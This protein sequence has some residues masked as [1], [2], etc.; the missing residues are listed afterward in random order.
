MQPPETQ[1]VARP[2]GVSIAY[3]VFG[4]GPIDLLLSPGLAS[5][6]DMAWA[7][8]DLTRLFRR[9]VGFARV[10]VY[11]KPGTGL[12]DP[13]M[14]VPTLEERRDD[15]RV[16]L[17]AV[18]SE[19]T[20]LLGFSEGGPACLLFAATH[21]ER[22]E[23]LVLYGAMACASPREEELGG[24]EEVAAMRRN[25]AAARD[26]EASWGQG[27]I[28][29]YFAPS[30]ASRLQRSAFATFERAAASP[31]MIRGLMEAARRID[32]RGALEAV[33]VPTL[34]LHHADDIVPV[35]QARMLADGIAGA[36][37]RILPGRDHMFWVSDFEESVSEIERFLAGSASAASPERA[38]ATILFTDIV[39]STARASELGDSAWRQLLERHDRV[40]RDQVTDH[41]GRIVK[42]LG[43][44]TLAV[45]DGPAR[46]IHC[47]EAIRDGLSDLDI[48]VRS[49][50]HTGECE[51]IDDDVGGLAVHIGAR[52]GALAGAGE[53]LVSSTVAD[54]VVGSGLRFTERGEHELKGVPGRWKLLA[55]GA[56]GEREP[57]EAGFMGRDMRLADRVTVRLAH[58]APR[59]MRAAS[60]W[61]RR[62]VRRRG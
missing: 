1:Y 34:V 33:N 11:D 26:I 57:R 36:R 3:Q 30:V 55:V 6:L 27:K 19:R 54:L 62:S 49:G 42:S 5:H 50:V 43:D 35:F 52:I 24:P 31:A 13:I 25:E 29:D 23:S 41:R 58:R 2:D 17:D 39:G 38:L 47:A 45:F 28:I 12:S 15:I 10:I 59:V 56:P 9:L 20:A 48:Q 8:P 32:V 14:H 46:A 37:L 53:I 22:V 61:G 51:L 21:P 16:L 40:V 44:G 60:E 18:P 7:D 4:A